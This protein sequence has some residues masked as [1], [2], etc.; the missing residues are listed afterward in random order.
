MSNIPDF[1]LQIQEIE[2]NLKAEWKLVQED[3]R[4]EVAERF[5][6]NVMKPYCKNFEQYITGDGISGYGVNDLMNQ[7]DKHLQDM[8]AL[9]G[10]SEDVAFVCAAGPQYNGNIRNW[11]G[12]DIDVNTSNVVRA[13]GGIVHDEKHDRDYWDTDP[14]SDYY[15]GAKPGELRDRDIQNIFNNK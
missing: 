10:I 12:Q 7:M 3:W 6:S 13:R 11:Y 2:R 9:T 8:T 5:D 4:D 15:D 1:V 14:R